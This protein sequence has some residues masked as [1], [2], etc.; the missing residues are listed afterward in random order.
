MKKRPTQV[1]ENQKKTKEVAQAGSGRELQANF[2]LCSRLGTPGA[3]VIYGPCQVEGGGARSRRE[4]LPLSR[5]AESVG[6]RGVARIPECLR[7]ALQDMLIPTAFYQELEERSRSET[8]WKKQVDVCPTFWHKFFQL[9][10]TLT[11]AHWFSFL[12]AAL[13]RAPK[14]GEEVFA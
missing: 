2:Q 10:D 1:E 3:L 11:G 14:P 6:P 5:G 7:A 12:E 4:G 9:F 8:G 13:Q